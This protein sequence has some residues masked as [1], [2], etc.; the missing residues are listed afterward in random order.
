MPVAYR[1][2]RRT[3]SP[4]RV[5]LERLP[6]GG[7]AG[8]GRLL[9]RFRRSAGAAAGR[10][11]E[12]G[13]RAAGRP[14]HPFAC[15]PRRARGRARPPGQDRRCGD[16]GLTGRGVVDSGP[17]GRHGRFRRQRRSGLHRRHAL[18]GLRRRR[19]L[20]AGAPVGDERPDEPAAADTRPA[21]AH[22]RDDD[23]AGVGGEPVHPSLARGGAGRNGASPRRRRR[24]NADRLV[25]GLR[26]RRQSVGSIRRRPRRDRRRLARRAPLVR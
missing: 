16:R 22:R 4:S 10:G 25:A 20:R 13:G 17:L 15:R 19:E 3:E 12:V 6:R 26:R 18:Q 7:R 11:R 24:R 2:A 1:R 14:P 5:P 21:R 8:R 9:R 23:R